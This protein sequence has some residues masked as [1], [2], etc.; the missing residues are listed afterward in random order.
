ML[1][2]LLFR[3]NELPDDIFAIN[4]ILK[5]VFNNNYD[6]NVFHLTKNLIDRYTSRKKIEDKDYRVVCLV[7]LMIVSK[8][9]EFSFYHVKQIKLDTDFQYNGKELIELEADIL[10]T[11]NFEIFGQT[12]VEHIRKI[13]QVNKPTKEERILSAYLSCIFLLNNNYLQ[14]DVPI[15]ASKLVQLSAIICSETFSNDSIASDPNL[16]FI[17]FECKKMCSK[18][19]KHFSTVDEIEKFCKIMEKMDINK[20]IVDDDLSI[21]KPNIIASIKNPIMY[22]PKIFYQIKNVRNIGKGTYGTVNHI[23]IDNKEIAL[24]SAL[25][26]VPEIGIDISILREIYMLNV[27]DHPSIIR[28]DGL[29]YD[30]QKE[31]AHIGLDLM[32]CTIRE[33]I[34]QKIDLPRKMK[35]IVQILVGLEYLHKNSICHRD[36]STKNVMIDNNDNIKIIDFG[37]SKH[38]HS[39]DNGCQLSQTVCALWYRSIELLVKKPIY[40][41]KIDVWSAACIIYLILIEEH[42]F[43]ACDEVAII[44]EIFKTFGTPT[45]EYIINSALLPSQYPTSPGIGLKKVEDKYPLHA[46]ILYQMFEYLPEKR[47]NISE[48]LIE[49]QKLV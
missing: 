2:K 8:V 46:K 40:D 23:I 30:H 24:K 4:S 31:S 16:M 38:F 5:I 45:T 3:M 44:N 7:C 33:K 15:L 49:F 29:Y 22:K 28:M 37:Q 27:L 9:E 19:P 47:I 39:K 10:R 43:T 25:N 21:F 48:A 36:L 18:I 20:D 35:Y 14:I 17:C 1:N 6:I 11:I 42:L 12:L 34:M 13:Y 41:Y 32:N 26:P